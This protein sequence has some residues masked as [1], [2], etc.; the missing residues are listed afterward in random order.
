MAAQ[1]PLDQTSETLEHLESVANA[2]KSQLDS[3][4]AIIAHEKSRL[5]VS[6]E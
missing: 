3:L 1:R 4:S 2:L 6:A 5:P